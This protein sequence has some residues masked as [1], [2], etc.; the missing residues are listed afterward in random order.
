MDTLFDG[1]A[2]RTS[3]LHAAD[4][5]REA[6]PTWFQS[7]KMIGMMLYVD[8]FAGDLEGVAERIPYLQELG[9]TYLHLMPLLKSRPGPNDG[10]YAVS[11]YRTVD[12]R[13]GTM[14][15]LRALAKKLREAGIHLVLD[16]VMNHTAREHAWAQAALRGEV[17]YQDFYF[18]FPD[19]ALPE[20]YERTLPEVFP[21]IAPGNF[22]WQPKIQRWAW[23]TFYPF[24]WDLNYTNPEVFTRVFEEM[25][26]LANL[27]VDV[28]RLDAVPFMW[29]RMGTNSQNQPEVLELLSAYRALMRIAAPSVLFKAE[30]IVAPEDIVRYLGV[31]GYEGKACDVAYHATLMN[32]LWHALATENTHLLRSTLKRLPST[33]EGEHLDQL[34][35]LPRR[36]WLGHLGR[37][38]GS[39]GTGRPRDAAFLRGLLRWRRL[40]LLRRRLPLSARSAL[41]RGA[42]VWDGG[43]AGGTSESAR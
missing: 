37:G 23:T 8:L 43:S 19:R 16:M 41:G 17:R 18:L 30:A 35:P 24:Q 25:L 27:G 13:L 9:I 1:T 12:P 21:E 4:A 29:K 22:T 32:H 3:D 15:A 11:D 2:A 6:D 14:D 5:A 39:G 33:P 7:P 42:D 26:F 40:R 38:S 34:R 10:G 28:L 31:G 20:A 36:H